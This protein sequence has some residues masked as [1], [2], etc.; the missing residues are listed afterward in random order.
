MLFHIGNAR[1]VVAVLIC[2]AGKI[3]QMGSCNLNAITLSQ[4]YRYH[5]T[6]VAAC[7]WRN[8]S[9]RQLFGTCATA[10]CQQCGGLSCPGPC[11]CAD[12]P[13]ACCP[14]GYCCTRGNAYYW[15]CTPFSTDAAAPSAPSS[16][17]KCT[18]QFSACMPRSV[19]TGPASNGARTLPS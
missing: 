19:F 16:P 7:G 17:G 8:P 15:Q 12:A 9:T 4:I 6:V 2:Q 11:T 1:L 13:G 10:G 18:S 5:F 14:S 3:E